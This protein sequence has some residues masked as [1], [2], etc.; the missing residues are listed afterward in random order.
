VANARLLRLRRFGNAGALQDAFLRDP[1]LPL[2]SVADQQAAFDRAHGP[3][4]SP[5]IPEMRR[6]GWDATEL[7]LGAPSIRVAWEREHGALP[8]TPTWMDDD[9]RLAVG[10]IQRIRPDVVLDSNLNVLDPKTLR[11]LRRQVPQVSVFAGYMGTE[12]RFH[13]A[14][15]LDLV[16]VPCRT[17]SDAIRP[18][19][20]GRT[21]IL[22]HSF[23]HRSIAD[24]PA[25]S[26]EHPLVFA[27]A[28]GPRYVERHRILMALLEQTEMEAWIGLRKGVYRT[29]DGWLRSDTAHTQQRSRRARAVDHLPTSLL[30]SL[31]VRGWERIG[32]HLNHRFVNAT[33]GSITEGSPMRDPAALYPARCHPALHGTAYLSL[34][35]RSGTVFHRGIDALGH[36]GGALRLF[37]VTGTGAALLVEDSPTVHE[38]FDV[39]TEAITYRDAQEAV[40]RARWLTDNP[41]ERERI[42]RAGHERTMRDHT[43][44]S[45][46]ASLDRILRG[47]VA[48]EPAARR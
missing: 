21:E 6:L 22:P 19:Q 13:R 26:V 29:P 27:G 8:P 38:L 10:E 36:C 32:D 45:R 37:E 30:A 43:A 1:D 9:T 33:G 25:R 3:F 40:E 35:R 18:L 11:L 4:S 17:M 31:A 20:W 5:L 14:L 41:D 2:R 48:G 46:A 15:G 12:K 23:D 39:G 28:L 7:V 24:L 34:L 47:R 16:L 44:T 42:A